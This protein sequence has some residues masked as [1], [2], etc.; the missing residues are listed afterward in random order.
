[1]IAKFDKNGAL[2]AGFG[3]NGIAAL[4]LPG[5]TSTFPIDIKADG[6]GNLYIGGS[7]TA[8]PVAIVPVMIA[9]DGGTGT[10]RSDF[11][12]QGYA[13]VDTAE[14]SSAQ[15]IT[16]DPAHQRACIAHVRAD[17]TPPSY[18]NVTCFKSAPVNEIFAAGFE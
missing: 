18:F 2:V 8:S 10:L 6:D 16:L 14:V 1:M 11:G 17:S 4:S 5:H 9:V 12:A 3:S 15:A 7:T 13:L